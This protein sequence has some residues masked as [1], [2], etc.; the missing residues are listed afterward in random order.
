MTKPKEAGTWV[1][2]SRL[3]SLARLP[4]D[5]REAKAHEIMLDVAAGRERIR[6][7]NADE[8]PWPTKAAGYK[9]P[10]AVDDRTLRLDEHGDWRI[11]KIRRA[12]YRYD[13]LPGPVLRHGEVD[14]LFSSLWL[15]GRMRAHWIEL[16]FPDSAEA[17]QDAGP[18]KPSE[19]FVRAEATKRLDAG[20]PPNMTKKA[21][22]TELSEW[23]SL[24]HPPR[25]MIPKAVENAISSLW[26]EKHKH[27]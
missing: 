20:V 6:Y 16:F 1:L 22:S 8:L 5:Q 15:E 23:L 11:A 24:N 25:R 3:P 7:L 21:F 19:F 14:W 13:R 10:S 27:F 4:R 26:R 17:D 2:L 9:D 12:D 18:R